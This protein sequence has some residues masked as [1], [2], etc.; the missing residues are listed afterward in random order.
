MDKINKTGLKLLPMRSYFG[1]GAAQPIELANPYVF[2]NTM[3]YIADGLGSIY[4]PDGTTGY[5]ALA[6]VIADAL[7]CVTVVPFG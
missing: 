3:T 4:H 1:G 6:P 7:V 2:E 5:F